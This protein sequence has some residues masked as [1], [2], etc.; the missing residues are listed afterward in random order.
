MNYERLAKWMCLVLTAG[1]LNHAL[2]H[3]R[4]FRRE[5]AKGNADTFAGILAGSQYDDPKKQKALIELLTSKGYGHLV[6][7]IE[8]P[9]KEVK[10]KKVAKK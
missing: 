2:Y 1:I 5:T 4:D 6:R 9:K 8:E 10:E 3:W 7:K